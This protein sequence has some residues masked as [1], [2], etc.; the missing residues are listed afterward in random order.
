MDNINMGLLKRAPTIGA[1]LGVRID[2][3]LLWV[4]TV[5]YA[6]QLFTRVEA[7]ECATLFYEGEVDSNEAGQRYIDGDPSCL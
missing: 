7:E 3:A 6:G 4:S 5:L 1:R 2:G